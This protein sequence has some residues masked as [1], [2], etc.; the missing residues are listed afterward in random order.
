MVWFCFL[1]A[2]VFVVLGNCYDCTVLEDKQSSSIL[3][4]SIF[5]LAD[6]RSIPEL[7]NLAV[8]RLIR[9]K[10]LQNEEFTM[11]NFRLAE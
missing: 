3:K 10:M 2:F 4:S 5:D 7:G 8:K 6:F 9:M 11:I 1:L